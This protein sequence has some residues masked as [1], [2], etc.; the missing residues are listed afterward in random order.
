MR[1]PKQFFLTYAQETKSPY[2]DQDH[3]LLNCCP[4]T[5]Y[6]IF[7]PGIIP[8]GFLLLWDNVGQLSFQDLQAFKAQV[9]IGTNYC[10][11]PFAAI[12]T[13]QADR[14]VCSLYLIDIHLQVIE[15]P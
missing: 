5:Q 8:A 3:D 6:K 1:F 11:I 7:Y 12:D 10:C 9:Y 14:S 15:V 2:T 4:Y 13:W